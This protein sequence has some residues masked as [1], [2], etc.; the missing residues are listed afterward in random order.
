MSSA[1]LRLAVAA[2]I[3]LAAAPALAS[4]PRV[5]GRAYFVQNPATGEVLLQR[6]ANTRVPIASL[7]K[8]MTA[9]VAL[10]HARPDDVVRVT[11]RAARAGS[12]STLRIFSAS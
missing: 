8:L 4:P 2:A 5:G 10:E 3:L 12:A 9:L 7:T 1:K 11:K 6:R